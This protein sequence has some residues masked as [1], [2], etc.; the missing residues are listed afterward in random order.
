[1]AHRHEVRRNAFS[2]GA[3]CADGLLALVQKFCLFATSRFFVAFALILLSLN[4]CARCRIPAI[5]PSGNRLFSGNL[6]QINLPRLHASDQNVGVIPTP[7]Y[8][9]PPPPPACL[10]GPSIATPATARQVGHRT[11]GQNTLDDRGRCGQL[12]LTPTRIVAPVN[13]DVILMSGLCGEDGYLVAGETIEWMISPESVGQIVSV[14]DDGNAQSK[15]F[16]H[17]KGENLVQKLDVDFAKGLT[18]WEDRI[19]TRG[20]AKLTD[21]LLVKKGQ[22]WIS[23][24]SPTEGTTRITALAPNAEVWDKR[25]QTATIYWVDA[26]WMFPS[27]VQEV[28]ENPAQLLTRVTRKEG[29]AP[30]EGW[31]VR[32]RSLDPRVALFAGNS[33][34]IEVKVD[35]NGVAATQVFNAA[36]RTGTALISI[37]VIRPPVASENMPQ[38]TLATG[39]TTVSW[40]APELILQATGPSVGSVNQRLTYSAS[41]SNIGNVPAGNV[42]L[43]MQIPSGMTVV[44]ASQTPTQTTNAALAWDI[45]EVQSNRMFAVNVEMQPSAESD[46]RVQFDVTSNSGALQSQAV[47]TL[48]S[49]P[50]VGLRFLPAQGSEQVEVGSLVQ[51]ELVVTNNGGT[52]LN[53]IAVTIESNPGLQSINQESNLVR[54]I[55]SYLA[56]GDS[57]VLNPAFTARQVGALSAT[58]VA[59]IN[60]VELARQTMTVQAVAPAPREPKLSLQFQTD[61][62]TSSVSTDS[63]K[64]IRLIVSNQGQLPL[65]NIRAT[66]NYPTSL[67]PTSASQGFQLDE[68]RRQIV[69]ILPSLEV[70][71]NSTIQ[72][73]FRFDGSESNPQINGSAEAA[74]QVQATTNLTLVSA[75]GSGN[76]MP[77]ASTLPNGNVVPDDNVLPNNN[78]L[79]PGQDGLSVSMVPVRPNVTTNTAGRYVLTVA[80][81]RSSADQNVQITLQFQPGLELQSVS[82]TD[83]RNVTVNYSSDGASAIFETIRYMA[84]NERIQFNVDV[85]HRVPGS[86]SL[87]ASAR[88][89]LSPN[90]VST[91]STAT[92]SN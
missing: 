58:A 37:E 6:T 4:G 56:P 81:N 85:L 64:L 13:G 12:L 28:G 11:N 76:V 43:S 87:N 47:A 75:N 33:D 46:Y 20:S 62:G 54:R 51:T 71:Q 73:E 39:Q 60:E 88:S 32:Y 30:A 82:T 25:R 63:A 80:N 67:T 27:P 70:G 38:L 26:R 55:V 50:R 52:A 23:L 83:G 66:I 49:S 36:R 34:V 91:T 44:S 2:V 31:I 40:S 29:F 92:V 78:V 65:R 86:W 7:G 10:E 8:R 89:T 48:V 24:T 59:T 14:G 16:F 57:Q 3:S 77:P 15:S 17:S 21:D 53:N 42:R 41:V 19:V 35:A 22:T 74:P 69:W 68:P 72:A 84:A 79:P 1:M 18:A 45:G 9:E 5:D 90:G 61:N